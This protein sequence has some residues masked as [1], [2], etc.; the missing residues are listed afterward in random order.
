[1]KFEILSKM[2]KEKVNQNAI[3]LLQVINTQPNPG[4]VDEP[5]PY[6]F[7]PFASF[8]ITLTDFSF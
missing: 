3:N 2:L 1:M 4:W 5:L 7:T 8:P 6:S